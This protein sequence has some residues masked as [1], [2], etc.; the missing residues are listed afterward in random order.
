MSALVRNARNAASMMDNIRMTR[1][2]TT[3]GFKSLSDQL[4]AT[5]NGGR[6]SLNGRMYE[7]GRLG[8]DLTLTDVNLPG[9]T[10]KVGDLMNDLYPPVTVKSGAPRIDLS[11]FETKLKTQMAEAGTPPQ[12]IDIKV[13]A[14][15]DRVV[16]TPAVRRLSTMDDAAKAADASLTAG[17]R[18]TTRLSETQALRNAT[19]NVKLGQ[20]TS[21]SNVR[22]VL[23]E[24]TPTTLSKAADD[25]NRVL[26]NAPRNSVRVLAKAADDVPLTPE[27]TNTVT[28][29]I[30]TSA[31]EAETL[32]SVA[33]TCLKILAAQVILV[34]IIVG[35]VQ[36]TGVASAAKAPPAAAAATSTVVNEGKIHEDF[37]SLALVAAAQR[38]QQ[39]MNGCWLYDKAEGT[40]TK[41]KLLTCREDTLG[42]ETCPTQQYTAGRDA[43]IT[44]CPT[45]TFNP[46]LKS[47]TQRTSSLT[48]PRVPNVCNQY[49]YNS[50][51]Q[52]APIDLAGVTT[53]DACSGLSPDQSC[54]TYCK[55][56]MFNLP[57]HME[58]ICVDMD[59]A[60]AYAD[61]MS[62]L[63]LK[64]AELFSSARNLSNSNPSSGGGSKI[65]RWLWIAGGVV[66][67]LG[68]VAF[69]SRKRVA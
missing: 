24:T 53:T 62:Q 58:L 64:P 54:S 46:C 28:Q 44:G 17:G 31:K 30:E 52:S 40:M 2:P 13:K 66:L 60:T 69:V 48:T 26:D 61:L 32:G 68:L 42:I 6:F 34:G 7:V 41:V 65:P 9:S 35:I 11:K 43:A 18:P 37:L 55:T 15:M 49:L 63:N 8:D 12:Q 22:T 4:N 39:D 10:T 67:G 14:E 45:K 47:S 20:W 57:V 38:Y 25:V 16:N 51:T 33:K 23:R 36:V 3:G 27:Q 19:D 29:L 21:E 1:N 5:P 59:L 56:E 50:K